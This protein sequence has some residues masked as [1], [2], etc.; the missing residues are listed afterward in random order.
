MR[1]VKLLF[2]RRPNGYT[3]RNDRSRPAFGA[4]TCVALRGRDVARVAL[5]VHSRLMIVGGIVKRR[6][7]FRLFLVALV[8]FGLL[9][10]V[11]PVWY[12]GKF[13]VAPTLEAG[14]GAACPACAI[15]EY[16]HDGPFGPLGGDDLAIANVLCSKRKSELMA[17]IRQMANTYKAAAA[18]WGV[19]VRME[20]GVTSGDTAE[21]MADGKVTVHVPVRKEHE[22]PGGVIAS[23]FTLDW[24]FEVV[25][26]SGWRICAVTHPDVCTQMIRCEGPQPSPLALGSDTR[27]VYGRLEL[28]K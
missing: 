28:S 13:L 24:T 21:E 6:K 11:V 23:T 22:K 16:F 17:D 19:S 20:P 4:V 7:R 8:V 5:K 12:L 9:I 15:D 27:P 3:M 1:S 25:E 10:L 18:K 14:K 2:D 26:E